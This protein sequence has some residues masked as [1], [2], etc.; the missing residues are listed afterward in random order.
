MQEQD[1]NSSRSDLTSVQ[2]IEENCARK[3]ESLGLKLVAA[4]SNVEGLCT[5]GKR[6]PNSKR[7]RMK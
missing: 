3:A 6:S 4:Q 5:T 1:A 7:L 2:L